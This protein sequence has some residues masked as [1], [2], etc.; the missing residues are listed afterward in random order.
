M[1]LRTLSAAEVALAGANGIVVHV[2]EDIGI[3]SSLPYFPP[4]EKPYVAEELCHEVLRYLNIGALT[5]I[6]NSFVNFA[7]ILLN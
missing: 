5:G 7:L 4:R 2:F 3:Q 6:L 1:S